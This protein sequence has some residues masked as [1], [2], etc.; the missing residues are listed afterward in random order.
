M[1]SPDRNAITAW[2][3]IHTFVCPRGMGRITPETCAQL[4][5]RPDLGQVVHKD[6]HGNKPVKYRP[7]ACRRCTRYEELWEDVARRRAEQKKQ[8]EEGKPMS[9][10]IDCLGCEAEDVENQSRGLCK[11]CYPRTPAGERK[12]YSLEEAK[13]RREARLEAESS[14]DLGGGQQLEP[15]TS[16]NGESEGNVPGLDPESY[17][18]SLK[19]SKSDLVEN[20]SESGDSDPLAGF[21][22]VPCSNTQGKSAE[23]NIDSPGKFLR[24]GSKV[25]QDLSL[26]PGTHVYVYARE[27]DLALKILPEPDRLSFK[28]SRDGSAKQ[29]PNSKIALSARR[30]VKNG[31]VHPG[32]RFEASR[33]QDIIMLNAVK[34]G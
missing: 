23:V 32:Q 21:E 33:K 28:L 30:L 31:W 12:H 34:E 25:V 26:T 11:Q 5:N 7:K 27:N 15:S 19:V 16:V 4:R 8:K 22:F 6:V 2:Q 18:N 29:G 9:T 1:S 14:L 24:F 20:D 17:G 3:E 13:R 10:L